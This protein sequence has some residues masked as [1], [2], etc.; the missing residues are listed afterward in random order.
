MQNTKTYTVEEAK[1]LLERFCVYQDRCHV[2]VE[3]RL[4]KLNMIAE[5]KELI[6]IHLIQHDFLN[7]ERFAKSFVRGKFNQKKWGKIKLK[8]ELNFR[9]ISTYN[10]KTAFLEIDDEDY[11]S[12]IEKLVLKKSNTLSEN[13]LFTKK[14]KVI[15]YLTQKGYELNM[16]YPIV[17]ELVL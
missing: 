1:R 6:I 8:N 15:N 11:H 5:A 2:E 9:K 13:N 3:K 17:N 16:V 14:K 10:I 12:A 4:F 7:E